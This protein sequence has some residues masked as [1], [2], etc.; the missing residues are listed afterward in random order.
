MRIGTIPEL[1]NVYKTVCDVVGVDITVK[2]RTRDTYVFGRGCYYLIAK[3]IRGEKYVYK[4]QDT[5]EEQKFSDSVIADY[6][7]MNHASSINARH[8]IKY[9]YSKDPEFNRLY[10]LCKEKLGYITVPKE[11]DKIY[12]Q[13]QVDELKKQIKSLENIALD[14][15]DPF[16]IE[17]MQQPK[18]VREEF[19]LTRWQIFKKML[20]SRKTYPILNGKQLNT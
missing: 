10:E 13:N 19:N 7:G 16:I 4:L 20:Q 15:L 3:R 8:Q 17:I 9:D 2:N 1:D 12:T 11:G 18:H 14:S 5:I 6:I